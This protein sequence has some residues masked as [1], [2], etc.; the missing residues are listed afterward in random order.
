MIRI[1]EIPGR[2][3]DLALAKITQGGPLIVLDSEP[4]VGLQ[5]WTGWPGADGRIHVSIYTT[6]EPQALTQATAAQEVHAGLKHLDAALAA[7]PHLQK[8]FD[9]FGAVREYVFAYGNG[10]V[11][12]GDVSAEGTLTLL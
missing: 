2:R 4:P 11:R 6:R 5:R 8:S 12:V 10:A 3:W 1:N 7:D 9:E